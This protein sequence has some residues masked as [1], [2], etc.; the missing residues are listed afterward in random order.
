MPADLMTCAHAADSSLSSAVNASGLALYTFG[1][2]RIPAA[3][4][5]LLAALEVPFTP[6]WVF[7]FLGETPS[8]QTLLGGAIVLAALFLHIISEFRRRPAAMAMPP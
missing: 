3:E 4:A 5:T 2:K 6:F 7:V 8:P 1:S